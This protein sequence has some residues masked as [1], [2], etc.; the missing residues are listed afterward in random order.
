MLLTDLFHSSTLVPLALFLASAE[1]MDFCVSDAT[2]LI[3]DENKKDGS[4]SENV[5]VFPLSIN[6]ML[7]MVAS[8][9]GGQTLEQFL[10]VLG[11]KD[12][13]DFNDKSSSMM[14]LLTSAAEAQ[15]WRLSFWGHA[16][17][18]PWKWPCWEQAQAQALARLWKQGKYSS[19]ELP[20]KKQQPPVFSLA[21]ALWVDNG[22]PLIPS[23]K[24]ITQSI[25]KAGDYQ[26]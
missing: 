23:F 9:S 12:I 14:A 20:K 3:L 4:T 10:K 16:L 17:S 7:N 24:E 1:D 15:P 25:Y 22:S 8:G 19:R 6:M 5:L 13:N 11:S 26:F 21:K 18:R 2:Q